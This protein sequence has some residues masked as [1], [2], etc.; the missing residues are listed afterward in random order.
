MLLDNECNKMRNPESLLEFVP[1]P[2]F[3]AQ[4][5]VVS[6]DTIS[7]K[8]GRAAAAA[9]AGFAAGGAL[10]HLLLPPFWS[11]PK[12]ALIPAPGQ[13][14]AIPRHQVGSCTVCNYVKGG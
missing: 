7:G 13:R 4:L 5:L 10:P 2:H 3:P 8:H 1:S 12:I 11:L 6:E 9:R 14:A